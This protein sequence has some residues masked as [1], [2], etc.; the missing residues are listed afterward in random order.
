MRSNIGAT[1]GEKQIEKDDRTPNRVS[2]IDS[3]LLCKF[4]P[5]GGGGSESSR[6]ISIRSAVW[7]LQFKQL[8]T[9]PIS[10]LHASPSTSEDDSW[11]STR[12]SSFNPLIIQ[13][14][15]HRAVFKFAMTS[16]QIPWWMNDWQSLVGESLKPSHWWW[17]SGHTDTPV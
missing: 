7:V 11:F 16:L 15:I 6:S 4:V 9:H 12:K 14:V 5:F 10:S 8:A 13:E 17:N 3:L 1:R 2:C